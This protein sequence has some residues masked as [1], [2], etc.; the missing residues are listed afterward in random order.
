MKGEGESPI[1][2]W[3]KRSAE[4]QKILF[5]KGLSKCDGYAK[6][7]AHQRGQAMD[8]LFIATDN[9]IVSPKKGWE[10]WH[11]KWQELGGKPPIEWDYN[12]F[13]V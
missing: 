9:E 12:H 10:Y 11:K 8:I 4:E 1:I 13:E 3:V 7:S 2:D 6:I 5:D